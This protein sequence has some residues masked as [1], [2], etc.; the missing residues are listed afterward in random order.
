MA[1]DAK[2]W[3]EGGGQ[4]ETVRQ[5]QR[6][7]LYKDRERQRDSE[8]E[9]GRERERYIPNCEDHLWANSMEQNVNVKT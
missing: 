8:A 9:R 6:Q 4:R 7:R 5:R 1:A 2:E 3:A